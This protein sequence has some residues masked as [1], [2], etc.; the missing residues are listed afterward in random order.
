LKWQ[1]KLENEIDRLPNL[2]YL[3]PLQVEQVNQILTSTDLLVNTSQ[4]EGF[5]N[6]FI[7]AWFR[8]VP[9]LSLNCDPENLLS[10]NKLGVFANGC[11]TI[12]RD[13][14]QDLISNREKLDTLGMN[15]R[16][17]AEANHSLSNTQRILNILNR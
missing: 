9:V 4:Y 17:H 1:S 11:Y 5:S 3:G 13:S 2:T 7:Q 6:T 10:S 12:L 14:L 15:A 8:R 16:L